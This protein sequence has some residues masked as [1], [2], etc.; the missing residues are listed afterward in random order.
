MT[1]GVDLPWLQDEEAVD[2]WN[3]LDVEYRD[4]VVLDGENTIIAYYNLSL[5]DI[6]KKSAY[7]D[8]AYLLTWTA[9]Q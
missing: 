7:D 8:L 9:E 3:L 4:V 1:D 5:N 2:A 6:T